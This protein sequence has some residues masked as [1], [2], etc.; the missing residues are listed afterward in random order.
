MQNA[1]R[2]T[3]RESGLSGPAIARQLGRDRTTVCLDLWDTT[4]CPPDAPETD[5]D[6]KI[7]GSTGL[8]P[9]GGWER[10]GGPTV[11]NAQFLRA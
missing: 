2:S 8:L 3:P 9:T 11:C 7:R 4:A 10:T 5:C 6:G 1:A